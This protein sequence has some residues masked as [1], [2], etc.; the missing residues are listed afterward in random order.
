MEGDF[1]TLR[2]LFAFP[3]S[4]SD[5]AILQQLTERIGR[6]PSSSRAVHD[7]IEIALLPPF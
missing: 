3:A 5:I 4:V 1:A 2:L 7:L 6:I